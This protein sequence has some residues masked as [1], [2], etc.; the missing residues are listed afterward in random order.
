MRHNPT[1][2]N[3]IAESVAQPLSKVTS[4]PAKHFLLG[5]LSCIL[6]IQFSLRSFPDQYSFRTPPHHF[7]SHSLSFFAAV[8]N[9][10]SW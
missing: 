7:K 1:D 5:L 4:H 8:P 3:N 6:L 2:V 9:G 10:P